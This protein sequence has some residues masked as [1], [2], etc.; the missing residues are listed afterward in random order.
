MLQKST[1]V[2]WKI[3]ILKKNCMSQCFPTPPPS[4][5]LHFPSIIFRHCFKV[6]HISVL[7]TFLKSKSMKHFLPYKECKNSKAFGNVF[8]HCWI[9][10]LITHFWKEYF[11]LHTGINFGFVLGLKLV[12]RCYSKEHKLWISK[13]SNVLE[14]EHRCLKWLIHSLSTLNKFSLLF[15]C[16]KCHTSWKLQA[17]VVLFK[18]GTTGVY[19]FRKNVQCQK[20]YISKLSSDNLPSRNYDRKT[21]CCIS[22][23]LISQPLQKQT[24][25]ICKKTL[26]NSY[27]ISCATWVF[28]SNVFYLTIKCF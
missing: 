2:L 28:I 10:T 17:S 22:Q 23:T 4:P 13:H 21:T 9:R 7:I 3:V 14:T 5:N 20:Y 24:N 12:L 18:Y 8:L 15:L 1:Y 16:C 11:K 19:S 6:Q 25:T 27:C 26:L